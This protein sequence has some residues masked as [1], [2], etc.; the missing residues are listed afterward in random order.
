MC[1]QGTTA[2]GSQGLRPAV[3]VT[4]M[5]H[6]KVVF[7][8]YYGHQ[9][10]LLGPIA[11]ALPRHVRTEH[12][13]VYPLTLERT[14]SSIFHRDSLQ[15]D[16]IDNITRYYRLKK[17]LKYP[18][19]DTPKWR[20]R[21]QRRANDWYSLFLR[22]LTGADLLVIWN[23]FSIPLGSAVAAARSLGITVVFCENGALPGMIAMDT[24]G[25]NFASSISGKPAEFYQSISVDA[26]K[27][28][29][30]FG[31]SLIQRPLRKASQ[32]ACADCDDDKPLPERYVL[33]AMQVHDDTQMLLFSP[34]FQ[35]LSEAVT[36]AYRRVAEYSAR[37]G[38]TLKLIVKEH[39]SDFGRTDYS[40]LRESLPD[41]YFLR[42][43]PVSEL[44]AHTQAVLTINSSVGVE[45]L[46][47]L[48]PVITLGDA[49][50]NVPGIVR[51]LGPEDDLADVLADTIG[52][53]VNVDLV[54]KFLYFLRYEYLVS[55]P[56]Q[57]D[58]SISLQ[59]AADRILDILHDSSSFSRKGSLRAPHTG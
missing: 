17:I 2:P 53:P 50:Y 30:M 38:D 11:D 35:S 10:R 31:T 45:G 1:R 25:I 34:R 29:E 12:L 49:F 41:A 58:G 13:R 3:A 4:T 15:P 5:S 14:I 40:K 54:T 19:I 7:L 9:A 18:E 8:S 42:K 43:K 37:T 57:S 20:A 55:T 44:V 26:Q 16:Q 47:H 23:G 21:L 39:P 28:E 46:L 27:A 32:D 22:K 52:K 36:Y 24:R 33:F 56:R 59:P 51:H 6:K 48:R